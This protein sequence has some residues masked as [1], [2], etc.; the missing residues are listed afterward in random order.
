V[1]DLETLHKLNVDAFLQAAENA[2]TRDGKHVIV[3]Y[4]GVTVTGYETFTDR[5]EAFGKL[6]ELQAEADASEHFKLLL[7]DGNDISTDRPQLL[8]N[9]PDDPVG[10][11]QL[12]E[13]EDGALQVAV[14]QRDRCATA[15]QAAA[16]AFAK[17]QD[18]CTAL[19]EKLRARLESELQQPKLL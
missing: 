12:T 17:A 5:D 15:L 9:E 4:D 7:P 8:D 3:S 6:K 2:R 1:Q 16:F 10:M 11:P 13:E 19:A 14:A 18:E